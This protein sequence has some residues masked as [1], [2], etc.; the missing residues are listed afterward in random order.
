MSA[1]EH[2]TKN[3]ESENQGSIG[4]PEKGD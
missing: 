4:M 3:K 1:S 2:G